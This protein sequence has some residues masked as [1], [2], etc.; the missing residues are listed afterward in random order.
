MQEMQSH[1]QLWNE[2]ESYLLEK[3]AGRVSGTK[4][5]S[6]SHFDLGRLTDI[7]TKLNTLVKDNMQTQMRFELLTKIIK[8]I[9]E[10]SNAS[11]LSNQKGKF[12]S[13]DSF[14]Y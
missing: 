7:E 6:S 11:K 4:R 2:V 10:Q 5:S 8:K 14:F 3:E 13:R 12:K 1:M 9:Q